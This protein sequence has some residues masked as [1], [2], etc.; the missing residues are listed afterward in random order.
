MAVGERG[1]RPPKSAPGRGVEPAQ[2]SPI[3]VPNTFWKPAQ[4]PA[5][6]PGLEK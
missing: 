5:Y 3:V 1:P 4:G 2:A 6:R